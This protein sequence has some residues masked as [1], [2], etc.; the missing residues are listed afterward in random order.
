MLFPV[1]STG[2]KKLPQ[3]FYFTAHSDQVFLFSTRSFTRVELAN[4][5]A[6]TWNKKKREAKFKFF[7][8]HAHCGH[9]NDRFIPDL[10]KLLL[11][12]DLKARVS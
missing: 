7:I 10:L 2:K 8:Q 3:L 6:T 5:N 1:F 4:K 9:M 11:Q 12:G